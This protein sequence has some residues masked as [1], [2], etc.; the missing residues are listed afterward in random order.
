MS[1][2][3]DFYHGFGSYLS[4]CHTGYLQIADFV[5]EQKVTP[6]SSTFINHDKLDGKKLLLHMSHLSQWL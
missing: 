2:A 1:F 6:K 3:W 4:R 5:R